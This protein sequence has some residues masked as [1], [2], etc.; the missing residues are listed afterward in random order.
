MTSTRFEWG[1]VVQAA[2]D[3]PLRGYAVLVVEDEALVAM[4]L[5]DLLRQQGC[6]V[7]G[8]ASSVERALALL[9]TQ[10]PDVALLDL[11]LGGKPGLPVAMA[12][13]DRGVPF[14]VMS[15]YSKTQSRDQD[16]GQVR[17][18]TKPVNHRELRRALTDMLATPS[19]G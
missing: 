5:A 3:F 6:H 14:V 8:P 17:W 16:L 10:R 19:S 18:L 7:L 9:A 1:L 13:R 2:D 11:N 15:G 12:L 4:E